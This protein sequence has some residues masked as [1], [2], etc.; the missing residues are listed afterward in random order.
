MES[1]FKALDM[2]DAVKSYGAALLATC[3]GPVSFKQALTE[4]G[5][6]KKQAEEVSAVISPRTEDGESALAKALNK[7][8][9]DLS[10]L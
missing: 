4:L 10:N 2:G 9:A 8:L 3:D 5:F 1:P 6:S 7:A